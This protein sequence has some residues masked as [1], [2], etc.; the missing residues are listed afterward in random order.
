MNL[1]QIN[2]NSKLE[3]LNCFEKNP[4]I[5]VGISG[6]PDSMCLAHLLNGWTK[7][8]KGKFSALVF[9]HGIRNDSKAES[10]QVKNMLTKTL[11]TKAVIIKP[12]K[13]T[14]IKKSM[15]NARLNRFVGLVGFCNKNNIPHLF[16]GHHIDDNL[17]TF[18]IRKINGSNLE[19]LGSMNKIT[20]YKNI[21]ILR[22]LI[23]VNKTSILVYNKKNNVSYLNDPSN[24][25]INYT[26]VK[27]RNFLNKKN[28]KQT[29]K[30]DFFNL[31]KEIPNYK[32][33][34]LE[35]FLKI[36]YDVKSNKIKIKFDIFIK[37]DRLIIE[38][39]ILL[40]LKF[41]NKHKL[42]KSSKISIFIE[43]LKSKN[44][45]IFNLSGIIIQKKSNFLIFSLN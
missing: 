2:F 28:V 44:F 16:L 38:K 22:P 20:F 33:M 30:K 45:K 29:V 7:L 25:D 17:E 34:I 31:K 3:K 6:G 43:A 5:A 11:K 36:L 14:P 32:K 35:L 39:H 21:Q 1:N 4:H 27:V 12:N 8:K 41:L 13:N 26:R 10:L 9:D 37:F 24:K 15:S 19:G 18:L 40:I 23:E 42:T